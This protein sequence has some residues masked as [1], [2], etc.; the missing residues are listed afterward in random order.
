MRLTAEVPP[1][2]GDLRKKRLRR[3]R[4]IIK[5]A[6]VV[7]VL[8][9]AGVAAK[10]VRN[11]IRDWQARRYAERALASMD[12][13]KWQEAREE[14]IT[15]HY[16]S[17]K[18][19][20]V[21]R[22]VARLLSLA[23]QIDAL[24]FW[25]SLAAVTPLTRAD[26]RNE[27]EIALKVNDIA[28]ADEA[29][30]QLLENRDG[31][32]TSPDFLLAAEVSMQERQFDKATELVQKALADPTATRRDQLQATMALATIIHDSEGRSGGDHQG[33]NQR[34]AEIGKG[35]DDVA[36]D[37]LIA[38]AQRILAVTSAEKTPSVVPIDQIVQAINNHPLAKPEN[39]LLA[40][41][42]EISEHKDRSA[43]IERQ[44]IDRWKNGNNEEL[45]ALAGWLYRRGE[46]QRE[47]DVIPLKQATQTQELFLHHIDALDALGRWDDIRRILESE[48]FPFD[49]VTQS[50]YLARCY[51]KLGQQ[52][53]AD[54]NWRS[55]LE[56][57]AGNIGK[58]LT[59][60]DYAEKSGARTVAAKA[61]D[62]A[63]AASP[64]SRPAEQGRLRIA[65]ADH[66]T[67]RIHA[68]LQEFLKIWPKD[69]ALLN[70]EAYLR[71]LLLPNES[72]SGSGEPT[73]S[74]ELK[75]IEGLAESLLK[76]D[77][78]SIPN[79]TLLALARLRQNRAAD[80]LAVYKNVDVPRGPVTPASVVVH[81]AVLAA[82]GRG[83][84]ARA[85]ITRVPSESL[86]PEERDLTQQAT[87]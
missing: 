78:T 49:A 21:I 57:A 50:M 65:Y 35:S 40:V 79:R 43:E 24:D 59:L 31:K 16:L 61:Y 14:V 58:L 45:T 53:S 67:K 30:H 25:K 19:P 1:S 26:L 15:A 12:H 6:A 38:L 48:R 60:G 18:E 76:Q 33:I 74:D 17:A 72:T 10:P 41:D 32:P 7:L 77:P 39:K 5:I 23:G 47:L 70:D 84:D 64:R 42:L 75:N 81:A 66:D 2:S 83:S 54:N 29:T 85:E 51:M 44:T 69:V 13:Q 87:K 71:L 4:K 55:A 68:L 11:V 20:Q 9:I 46:Y 36:L 8:A 86:L 73:T 34:L 63:A 80:A 37:A 62:A 27:A 52:Q 82:N 3:R 22:A 56:D 28:R